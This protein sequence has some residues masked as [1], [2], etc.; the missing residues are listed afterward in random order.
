MN[1]VVKHLMHWLIVMAAVVAVGMLPVPASAQPAATTVVTSVD[2]PSPGAT[3]ENGVQIFIGGWAVDRSAT[4]GTG[5]DEVRVYLDG[6]MNAGGTLLG[7]ATLGFSRPDVAQALG[8]PAYAN[9]GFNFDWTPTQLSGG[10]HTIYVHAHASASNTWSSQ[11]V[12]VTVS[13]PT[14]AGQRPGGPGGEM[15]RRGE[16][17]LRHR[18]AED[19][20]ELPPPPP[21][22]PPPPLL[23]VY[24]PS[25]QSP[26]QQNGLLT[27]SP[28]R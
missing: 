14:M 6:P 16:E 19:L 12:A 8:N 21:P 7:N 4:S 10:S 18:M 3:L 26:T 13:G 17:A 15:G 1:R 27:L 22:P 28:F 5:I 11:T 24:P 20:R 25:F 9:A 2:A 23:P